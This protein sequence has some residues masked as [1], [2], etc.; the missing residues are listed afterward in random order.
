MLDGMN[1]EKELAEVLGSKELRE[2]FLKRLNNY[3]DFVKNNAF[4]IE[5]SELSYTK[6][7]CVNGI[8]I[9]VV[10]LNSAWGSNSNLEKGNIILPELKNLYQS[11][12]LSEDDIKNIYKFCIIKKK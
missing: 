12:V 1:S 7:I 5:K 10:G 9:A 4:P 3:Y 8:E 6:N 2:I 11:A